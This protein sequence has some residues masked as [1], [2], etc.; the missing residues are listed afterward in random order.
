[1]CW[2]DRICLPLRNQNR[3]IA[4][5]SLPST[6]KPRKFT[7]AA[8]TRAGMVTTIP[9]GL[10]A[11]DCSTMATRRTRCERQFSQ[12]L[13]AILPAVEKVCWGLGAR[14]PCKRRHARRQA[15]IVMKSTLQWF[16]NISARCA[17]ARVIVLSSY[18]FKHAM[19]CE[20]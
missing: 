1:L 20:E 9:R 6:E 16:S 4:G 12:Q 5:M 15:T 17:Y 11:D 13:A 14:R 2:T 8:R 10:D 19:S 3:E 18:Q 7:P